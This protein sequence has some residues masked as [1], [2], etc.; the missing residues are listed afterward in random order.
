MSEA[1]GEV[2][3]RADL[4]T[5][6]D[7]YLEEEAKNPRGTLGMTAEDHY[8]IGSTPPQDLINN[9]GKTQAELM[10]DDQVLAKLDRDEV[11]IT[12]LLQIDTTF[13]KSA[14]EAVKDKHA[15]DI[16]YLTRVG[17]LPGKYKKTE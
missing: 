5:R 14:L 7:R 4:F 3:R 1:T 9:P 11:F 17:R 12:E 10:T 13:A 6:N 2:S 15:G 16:A 8:Y